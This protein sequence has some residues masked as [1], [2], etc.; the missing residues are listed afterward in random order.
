ALS[1]GGVEMSYGELHALSSRIARSLAQRGVGRGDVVALCIEP[2]PMFV[3]AAL[4]ALEAGAA[5]LPLDPSLPALRLQWMVEDAQAALVLCDEALAD[6]FEGIDIP[7]I[8]PAVLAD[9]AEDASK[10]PVPAVGASDA[11]YVIYTSGSTGRPKGVVVPHRGLSNLVAW[12]VHRYGVDGHDRASQLANLG[13]D[14]AV[15]ELWPYLAAGAA[16]VFAPQPVR[17]APDELQAWLAEARI[18]MCFAPTPMVQAMLASGVRDDLALRALL[19]GG[20]KLTRSSAAP[21][22]FV[23]VNHYGPT[24][25]SVVAT[26]CDVVPGRQG[27]PPIGEA[28]ANAHVYVLDD[29]LDHGVRGSVGELFIGGDSLADGYLGRP[30]ATAEAFLPDPWA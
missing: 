24:E 29:R 25:N 10:V 2:S 26:A 8:A 12:H 11:A 3:V 9:G 4:A 21:L 1:G 16:I 5:Y 19:T 17:Y 20:D 30:D 23:L 6:R 27:P 15:W 22:P 14:A 7:A 13:F 28:I 18:T